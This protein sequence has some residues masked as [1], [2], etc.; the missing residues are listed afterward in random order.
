MSKGYRPIWSKLR[1]RSTAASSPIKAEV[2]PVTANKSK[3][4]SKTKQDE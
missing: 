2:S 3:S 1:A 4:K